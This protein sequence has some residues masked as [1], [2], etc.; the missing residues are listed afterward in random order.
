MGKVGLSP[1]HW[2]LGQIG[3]DPS[4][5]R[6]HRS[7]VNRL[8]MTNCLKAKEKLRP[9][10]VGGDR[11]QKGLIDLDVRWRLG[12]RGAGPQGVGLSQ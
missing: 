10:V 9:Q 4:L 8:H 11:K 12:D 6:I 5:S 2:P 7:G 1:R 3:E